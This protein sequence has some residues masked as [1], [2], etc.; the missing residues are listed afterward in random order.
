[1]KTFLKALLLLTVSLSVSVP[2]VFSQG[3]AT[4]TLKEA[5]IPLPGGGKAIY[6]SAGTL[7]DYQ[8]TD[9]SGSVR[10]IST[11]SQTDQTSIEIAPFGEDFNDNLGTGIFD[12]SF[13]QMGQEDGTAGGVN[14]GYGALYVTPNREYSAVQGR[15][16]SPDPIIGV[17][18]YAYAS[19]NPI[20]RSD[21]S[22]LQDGGDWCDFCWYGDGS[23]DGNDFWFDDSYVGGEGGGWGWFDGSWVNNGHPII[24]S[25]YSS[26]V[27]SSQTALQALSRGVRT[28]WQNPGPAPSLSSRAFMFNPALSMDEY[29]FLQRQERYGTVNAVNNYMND[30]P[31]KVW[32]EA[33]TLGLGGGIA[34]GHGEIIQTNLSLAYDSFLDVNP[35]TAT[36][37]YVPEADAPS[38][39]ETIKY[40]ASPSKPL[41]GAWNR[42]E[43]LHYGDEKYGISF[44]KQSLDRRGMWRTSNHWGQLGRSNWTLGSP[45]F[46]RSLGGREVE[47]GFW[48]FD[49]PVTGY[50]GIDDMHWSGLK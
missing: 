45:E 49:K 36:F 25:L 46:M 5:Y 21:P 13:N 18:D 23:D 10:I 15:W 39:Y 20:I 44:Y 30:H 34:S 50:V 4:A 48:Y 27:S 43:A 35:T 40:R 38:F 47:P 12:F 1:M 29:I 3:T 24:K 14:K 9:G 11:P 26:I 8:R 31:Y 28:V 19:N 6:G 41:E 2:F 17:N 33:W 7:A 16:L 42:F 37:A 22:G 32:F